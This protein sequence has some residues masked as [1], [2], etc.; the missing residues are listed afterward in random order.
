MTRFNLIVS[1]HLEWEFKRWYEYSGLT[2]RD[3]TTFLLVQTNKVIFLW[4]SWQSF[5]D[6]NSM[7][8]FCPKPKTSA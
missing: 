2:A 3:R 7:G 5:P 4:Y 1:I 8:K 6:K